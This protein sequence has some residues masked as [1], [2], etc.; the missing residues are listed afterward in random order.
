MESES[1]SLLLKF[2]NVTIEKGS[3]EAEQFL[4]YNFSEPYKA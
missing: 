4:L 1:D 3:N 2:I